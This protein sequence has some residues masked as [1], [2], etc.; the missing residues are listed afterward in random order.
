MK[1]KFKFKGTKNSDG[2]LVG[3]NF[4]AHG[5]IEPGKMIEAKTDAEAEA[6]AE[7]PEFEEIVEKKKKGDPEPE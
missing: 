3:K 1:R 5:E 4:G 6:L 7:H 2:N